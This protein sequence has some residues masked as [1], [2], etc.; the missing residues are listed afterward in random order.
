MQQTNEKTGGYLDIKCDDIKNAIKRINKEKKKIENQQSRQVS[1]ADSSNSSSSLAEIS[2]SSILA[3]DT[4]QLHQ[5]P[6]TAHP[7][8]CLWQNCSM[9]DSPNSCAKCKGHVHRLCQ[10]QGETNNGWHHSK[11][12][13]YC[14]RC[15]PDAEAD[16]AIVRSESESCSSE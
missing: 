9:L 2:G 11:S 13:L 5:L 8:E 10:Y 6:N 14:C 7:N 12:I 4:S 3:D 15:H 16:S 1:P